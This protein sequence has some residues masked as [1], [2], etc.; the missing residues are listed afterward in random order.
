MSKPK[1][2]DHIEDMLEWEEKQYTPW[3][4]PQKGKMTPAMKAAGNKKL[5]AIPFL[6]FGGVFVLAIA[7]SLISGIWKTG[8]LPTL[9]ITAAFAVLYLMVGANYLRKWKNVKRLQNKVKNKKKSK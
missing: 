5:A 7:L 1:N 8:D 9:L 6:V 3:E 2:N 4:Y